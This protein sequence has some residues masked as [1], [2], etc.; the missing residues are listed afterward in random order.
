MI[1]LR[2]LR[3]GNRPAGRGVVFATSIRAVGDARST[4]SAPRR[5]APRRH[6]RQLPSNPGTRASTRWY[7]S[8]NLLVR[9][10][11]PA[12]S[13]PWSCWH[14][15][16]DLLVHLLG[17]AG[18]PSRSCWYGSP[19][20]LVRLPGPAGTPP[21]TCWYA[22]P[23]RPTRF[24]AASAALATLLARWPRSTV[25]WP[26]ST[27]C[28]PRSTVCWIRAPAC[29]D[30]SWARRR[31]PGVDNVLSGGPSPSGS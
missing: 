17:A 3:G 16:S 1:S 29:W 11:G 9:F 20:L 18:S 14:A 13:A 15:S 5:P 4:L 23:D 8:S 21:R 28:W 26:R 31:S 22:S 6:L 30:A 7:G 19:D 2:G 12:G 24:L 10:L 25:C 27:V